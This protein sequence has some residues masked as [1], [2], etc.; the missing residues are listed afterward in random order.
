MYFRNVC[1]LHWPQ[2]AAQKPKLT[3]PFVHQKYG[4]AQVRLLRVYRQTDQHEVREVRA[5]V[6]LEGDF[7]A[8]YIKADNSPVVATDSMKNL[9]NVLALEHL[10]T[11]NEPF[12]VDIA[13]T[14]LDRYAH[15]S[16]V[17][18]ELEETPW[19]RM[20]IDGQ[21]QAHSF[22]PGDGSR[23]WCQ[24]TLSRSGR[25][26]RSGIRGLQIMKTT[27]SGFSD[28][29]RDEYTTLP[30]TADR[31]L[32][33]RLQATWNYVKFPAS[34]PA[35]T[36]AVRRVLLRVFATTYSESVQ[37]SMYRMGEAV[38]AEVPE[39]GEITLAMPNIHYN[40][41]D[42]SA[43]GKDTANQLFLPTDEPHGDIEAT[44]RRD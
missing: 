31:I 21:V 11:D 24:V 9:V 18:V 33:T 37:D 17:S 42:L 23:M 34:Y 39:V 15:V 30:E 29:W 2:L 35:V 41:I 16:Q 27:K 32:C 44:L 43:F 22:Q 8:A 28:F 40:S 20:E 6:M 12:A 5:K 13:Q 38:F 36:A 3:M 25:E 1:G 19:Q 26:I 14:F 4:K 7:E 10:Q